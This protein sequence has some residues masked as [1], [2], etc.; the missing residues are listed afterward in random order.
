MDPPPLALAREHGVSNWRQIT[1][2]HQ[3]WGVFSP[4]YSPPAPNHPRAPKRYFH[5]WLPKPIQEPPRAFQKPSKIASHFHH[6]FLMALAPTWP[7]LGPNLPPTWSQNP[8]KILPKSH[9]RRIQNRIIFL[10][11]FWMDFGCIFD[12]QNYKKSIKN[13]S[14][15]QPN[16]TTT[17]VSKNQ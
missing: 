14:Q 6:R 11:T 4:S 15:T 7:Q 9:P 10:M 17:T 2:P 3:I 16:S 1:S 13:R 12:L 8:S 5:F